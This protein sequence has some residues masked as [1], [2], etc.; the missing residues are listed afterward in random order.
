RNARGRTAVIGA[1]AWSRI[2]SGRLSVRID[3]LNSAHQ[4]EA[5]ARLFADAD[6]TARCVF[7]GRPRP[8]ELLDTWMCSRCKKRP[9]MELLQL[10][11]KIRREKA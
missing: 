1:T 11:W 10:I 2:F 8:L 9:L 3:M 5:P 7:C 6:P 4:D